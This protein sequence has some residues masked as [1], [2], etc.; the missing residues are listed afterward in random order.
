MLAAAGASLY[1][2]PARPQALGGNRLALTWSI[3]ELAIPGET[4]L[5]GL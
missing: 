5:P 4:L 2:P 3:Q 1:P